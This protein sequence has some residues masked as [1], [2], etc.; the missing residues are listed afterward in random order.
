MGP[1]VFADLHIT[2]D[3]GM[4]VR[5]GHDICEAV[6]RRILDQIEEVVDVVVHLEPDNPA[7]LEKQSILPE[8]DRP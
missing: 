1:G 4:T 6:E 3:G 8:R 2:V 5:R 7:L